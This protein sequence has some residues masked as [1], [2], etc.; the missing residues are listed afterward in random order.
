MVSRT[1]LIVQVRPDAILITQPFGILLR[2]IVGT[3][4]EHGLKK[5]HLQRHRREIARFFQKL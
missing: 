4:D 1:L 5:T 3:V 2:A